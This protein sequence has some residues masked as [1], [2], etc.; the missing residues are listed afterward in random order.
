MDFYVFI[1][2]EIEVY[3]FSSQI[4]QFVSKSRQIQLY[5]IFLRGK[6]LLLIVIYSLRLIIDD[7]FEN[8][9]Y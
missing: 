6:Y 1:A 5:V 7:L 4:L 8:V 9:H 2:T 3:N